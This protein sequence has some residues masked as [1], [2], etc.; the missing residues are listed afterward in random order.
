MLGAGINRLIYGAELLFSRRKPMPRACLTLD[1][2]D[3][4]RMI[5]AAETVANAMSV[6]YC[7]AVV[8]A[9]GHLLAFGRQDGAL[10]GCIDLAIN[11]AHTARIFDKPTADLNLMA[12]PGAD[13]YGIQHSNGGGVMLIG[14]GLPVFR[15]GTV[16]GAVGASAGSV[17]EDIEVAKAALAVLPF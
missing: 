1:Y 5:S 3:A 7:I 17:E 8:D 9:G 15:N 13:L 10:I 4:Q 11:K 16:I 12:Q 6:P 14:G 2:S